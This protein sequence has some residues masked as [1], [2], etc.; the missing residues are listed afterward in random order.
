MVILLPASIPSTGLTQMRKTWN[1]YPG[2]SFIQGIKALSWRICQRGRSYMSMNIADSILENNIC[3]IDGGFGI[4]PPVIMNMEARVLHWP[5]D[6]PQSLA[7]II[8]NRRY[9]WTME[10]DPLITSVWCREGQLTCNTN[11]CHSIHVLVLD[12]IIIQ[13]YLTIKVHDWLNVTLGVHACM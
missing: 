4:T 13:F 10:I 12:T 5:E 8:T 6:P 1:L 3:I 7:I 2:Y 9:G 11:H